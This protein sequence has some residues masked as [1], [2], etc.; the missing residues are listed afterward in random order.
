MAIIRWSSPTSSPVRDMVAVQDEVNRLFDSFFSRGTLRGDSAPSFTPAV[1]IEETADAFVV[2]TDLP[3]ISPKDMKVSLM[4]DTLTIRGARR[5]D[6][7]TNEGGMR[8][9]ERI[10]GTFERSFVLGAPVRGDGVKAQYQNGVLEIRVPKAEE[11]KQREIEI[12][13][14]S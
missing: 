1:D 10:R 3:G 4:G 9:V 7:A 5:Q 14:A 2:R 11:A 13:V 6:G 12:Q 8:H